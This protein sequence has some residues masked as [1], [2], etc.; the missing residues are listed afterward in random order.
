M[1]GSDS[2]NVHEVRDYQ[3]GV[4]SGGESADVNVS[5]ED[6]LVDVLSSRDSDARHGTHETVNPP[7][8]GPVVE[9]GVNEARTLVQSRT[10][11]G[12][13]EPIDPNEL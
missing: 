6:Y 7:T 5:V 4:D 13:G 9:E 8:D 3:D 1:S 11:G 12:V 2:Q 10:I